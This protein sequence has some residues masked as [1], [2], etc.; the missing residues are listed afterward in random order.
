MDG[1]GDFVVVWSG[2]GADGTDSGI[3]AQIF[4]STATRS[5]RSSW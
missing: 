4:D 3:F 1:N 5:A 2:Q